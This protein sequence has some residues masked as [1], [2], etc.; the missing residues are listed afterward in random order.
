M[1]KMNDQ[2]PFFETGGIVIHGRGI[3]KLVGMPTANLKIENDSRLP[4]SGVYVSKVFLQGQI[5]YGI[6]HIGERPTIDDSK[7]ISFETHILN[8]NKDIYGQK[9]RVQ[10]FSKIRQL[11]KF[12]ELGLLLEQIRKDCVV[13]QQYWGLKGLRSDLSIDIQT[14][15]VKIN[16][17]EI[18][19]STKEFDVLYM[20]YLN[21]DAAFTKEQIYE[22]VWHEPA[23]SAY[24]AV[25]NTI[26][27]VRKKLKAFSE[28]HD[29]IKTIVGYGYK[30][31]T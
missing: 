13:V 8:F 1:N 19:L 22:A 5:L 17:Q 2:S 3:G 30:Y 24:H 14:H 6:T 10:L 4:Q 11:Q 27:Q 16:G 31:N 9:L 20:L 21:P 23:N 15:Q 29:Y 25:E 7:D 28:K 18:Y 26:F 12:D